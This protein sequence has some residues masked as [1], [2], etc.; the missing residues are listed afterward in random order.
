MLPSSTV[1]RGSIKAQWRSDYTSPVG[2]SWGLADF[3]CQGS[4]SKYCRVCGP[5]GPSQPLNSAIVTG[6]SHDNTKTDGCSR[7]LIIPYIQET[8]VGW[9]WPTGCSFPTTGLAGTWSQT[10]EAKPTSSAGVG[11]PRETENWGQKNTRKGAGRSDLRSL[12]YC[13]ALR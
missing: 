3:S 11:L 12:G 5:C 9:T 13:L 6:T 8:A 10:E 2:L 4:E 1:G 7:V